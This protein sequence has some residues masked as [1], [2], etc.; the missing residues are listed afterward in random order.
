MSNIDIKYIDA[1]VN[2][3][4]VSAM[5]V[6][7]IF[8]M[9]GHIYKE[10]MQNLLLKPLYTVPSFDLDWWSVTHFLLYAF[11]GF[12]KPDYAFTFFTLGVMFEVFEDIMSSDINTKLVNCRIKKVRK[13][14]I[15]KICC[16]GMQDSYWYSKIDDIFIN[17]LGYV[18][19]QGIRRTFY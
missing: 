1:N 9:I 8:I 15:G 7:I 11:F 19:G 5:V 4:I 13:S 12:V 10:Q 17:L 14:I 16:N 6:S 3:L 18:T 2:K